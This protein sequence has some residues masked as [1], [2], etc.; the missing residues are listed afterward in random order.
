MSG[1]DHKDNLESKEFNE[2][3]VLVNSNLT[4]G[5]S[6]DTRQ[7]AALT[8]CEWRLEDRDVLIWMIA[9]RQH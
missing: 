8:A 6:P 1:T 2:L 7:R 5:T 4:V 9:R 3:S